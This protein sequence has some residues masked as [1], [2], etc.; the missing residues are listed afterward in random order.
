MRVLDAMDLKDIE[1]NPSIT[2]MPVEEQFWHQFDGFYQL[3]EKSMRKELPHFVTDPANL[4]KVEA[5]LES[6]DAA[7]DSLKGEETRQIA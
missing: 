5:L 2:T 4:A 6:G 3:T 1:L 7:A